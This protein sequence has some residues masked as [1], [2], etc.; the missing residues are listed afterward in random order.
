LTIHYLSEEFNKN[1]FL[2]ELC[3]FPSPHD[4]VHILEKT[5][6]ILRKFEIEKTQVYCIIHDCASNYVKAFL[7]SEN[8]SIN[9]SNHLLQLVIN[10]SL[11]AQKEVM[12]QLKK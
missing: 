9:C 4:Y 12:M 10:S 2:L 5:S 3:E 8:Y 11:K 7:N 6:E 1:T